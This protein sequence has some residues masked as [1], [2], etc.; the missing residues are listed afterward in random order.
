MMKGLFRKT[1]FTLAE[2]LLAMLILLIAIL[3]AFACFGA[4]YYIAKK[5][6]KNEA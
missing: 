3:V 6:K 4:W 5:K 2:T 1:G